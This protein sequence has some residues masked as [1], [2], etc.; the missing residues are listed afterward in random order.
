MSKYVP[1]NDAKFYQ[2]VNK[3]YHKYK[4]PKKQKTLAQFCFPKK[5]ELQVP[6]K[7]LA[8]IIN[9]DTPYTGLLVY[10]RIGAGKTCTAINI[11]ERFK[12]IKK[13]MIVVPA[14]LKG[15]FRSELRSACAGNKYLKEN[16]RELLKQLHP[17]EPAYK[18]IIKKSDIRIDKYYT[19]YS[20][21]KF[22]S[23]IKQNTLKLI[24][25]LLIIDEVHNMVSET[26]TYYET[27]YDAIHS[28]PKTLRLIIMSAT[29]IFDKPMEIALTMNLLLRDKQMPTGSEFIQNFINIKHTSKGITYNAKNIELFKTYLRGYVSYYRGAPP[30]TFPHMELHIVRCKMS[31]K[32][33]KLYRKVLT[34]EKHTDVK[35]YVT[36]DISNSFFIGTRM[37]SNVIFPNGLINKDGFASLEDDDLQIAQIKQYSPKF[38]K[39]LRK[40]KKCEGTVFVYSNFKEYGGI[41]TLARILEHHHFRNYEYHGAGIR[42]FAIWTGDQHPAFKEEIKAV[43]NNKNNQDGSQIKVIL[44]SPSAKEGVSFLRVQ[45][46]HIIEPYWNWSRLDQIIGRAI[47]F[48]SHKDVNRNKQ[49][50]KVYIYLAVHSKIGKTVDERIMQMAIRKKLLNSEFERAIK[51]SAIDCELFKNANVYPGEEDFACEK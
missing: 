20:Y 19:I 7:F 31:D 11:A 30:Y 36:A 24:N 44:A 43:F 10:H 2:F 18:E 37:I 51:E 22:I 29:P 5:Y 3:K 45:E 12:N 34:L 49:L 21:N 14:S 27:L 6:Q 35:D 4:I 8:D 25:T 32:Q 40:I 9:P 28:A 13:I 33:V 17:S 16:E 15:N 1:V 23:L 50:V 46:V 48:C 47:R 39:I 38:L 26:G 42:R 41:K